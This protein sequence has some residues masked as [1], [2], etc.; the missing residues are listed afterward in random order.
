MSENRLLMHNNWLGFRAILLLCGVLFT[1]YGAFSLSVDATPSVLIILV[2]GLPLIAQ[3][4]YWPRLRV[5][6]SEDALSIHQRYPFHTKSYTFSFDLPAPPLTISYV[7]ND[8]GP[9]LYNLHVE[10]T[11]GKKITL[12]SSQ[13]KDAL[14]IQQRMLNDLWE[15]GVDFKQ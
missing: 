13:S 6:T 7:E 8:E 15:R 5:E 10:V 2:V 3:A 12:G 11:G 9:G 14:R 4:I 1:L